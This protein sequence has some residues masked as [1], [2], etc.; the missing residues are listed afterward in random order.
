MH[1]P[2][3]LWVPLL[4]SPAPD[5]VQSVHGCLEISYLLVVVLRL[6]QCHELALHGGGRDGSREIM[7]EFMVLP[8]SDARTN[9]VVSL[10]FI[11]PILR[12]LEQPAAEIWLAYIP[13]N[14]SNYVQ[15]DYS[16]SCGSNT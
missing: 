8:G 13:I 6:A 12:H 11:H 16:S 2:H 7:R 5:V 9:F 10:F 3:I 14:T 4:V 15:F 1:R